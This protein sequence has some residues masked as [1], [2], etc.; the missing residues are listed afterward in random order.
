MDETSLFT[1]H[2]ANDFLSLVNQYRVCNGFRCPVQFNYA[3]SKK[4][5][6]TPTTRR[7]PKVETTA[8]LEP[9]PRPGPWQSHMKRT[10]LLNLKAIFGQE[11]IVCLLSSFMSESCNRRGGHSTSTS[12]SDKRLQSLDSCMGKC[13]SICLRY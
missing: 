2:Y 13:C 3:G 12:R 5:P 8:I 11:N 10:R 9:V 6:Y 1:N 7:S 4:L